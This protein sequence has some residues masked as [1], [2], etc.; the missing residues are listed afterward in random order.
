[1]NHRGWEI[2]GEEKG[3][4]RLHGGGGKLGEHSN[5]T[6]PMAIK[7]KGCYFLEIRDG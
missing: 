5:S 4:S 7:G 3:G 1:M 6:T 2:H